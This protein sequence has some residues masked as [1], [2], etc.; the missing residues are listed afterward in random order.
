[1]QFYLTDQDWRNLW[2]CNQRFCAAVLFF[3][4]SHDDFETTP[5]REFLI[6]QALTRVHR[7]RRRPDKALAQRLSLIPPVDRL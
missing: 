2:P 4:T 3:A 7:A 1:M 6:G 5:A